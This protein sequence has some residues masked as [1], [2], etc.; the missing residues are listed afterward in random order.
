MQELRKKEE[1]ERLKALPGKEREEAKRFL[2][3]LTGE[4]SNL[5]LSLSIL[6]ATDRVC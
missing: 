6:T 5:S 1:Q 3:K 2:A 4:L